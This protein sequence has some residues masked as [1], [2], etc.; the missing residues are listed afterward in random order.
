MKDSPSPSSVV[1]SLCQYP[2]IDTQQLD[3]QIKT[4]MTEIIPVLKDHMDEVCSP[5]LL[6]YVRRL[7]LSL[8]ERP[9]QGQEFARF[10][11]NQLGSILQDSLAKFEGRKMRECGEDM[12]VEMSEILF[13][14]L[15]FFR[16]MQDLDD[17]KA[18]VKARLKQWREVSAL[19]SWVLGKFILMYYREFSPFLL[20][21][22]FLHFPHFN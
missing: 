3:M 15:A 14:E 16:L 22:G 10:F 20:A 8:T 11:R 7:V 1:I 13:N 17:P 21:A 19:T 12:L 6:Q 18:K 9:D 5:Q 2:R 4:V